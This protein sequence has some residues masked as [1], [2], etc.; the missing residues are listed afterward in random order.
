MFQNFGNPLSTGDKRFR[1]SSYIQNYFPQQQQQQSKNNM[2]NSTSFKSQLSPAFWTE[3]QNNF[4]NSSLKPVQQ[5]QQ[6]QPQRKV[7]VSLKR[8]NNTTPDNEL[9]I[10]NNKILKSV[11]KISNKNENAKLISNRLKEYAKYLNSKLALLIIP[12]L[13]QFLPYLR[14]NTFNW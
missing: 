6:Q 14:N 8:E 10:Q 9:N 13:P 2:N 11:S 7:L 4:I 12:N 3:F 1:G 5:Q